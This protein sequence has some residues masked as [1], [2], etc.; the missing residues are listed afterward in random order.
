MAILDPEPDTRGKGSPISIK[1]GKQLK[2]RLQKRMADT[3]RTN[4]TKAIEESLQFVLDLED[5][6]KDFE[7]DL[8]VYAAQKG[9]TKACAFAK[10]VAKGLGIEEIEC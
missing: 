2:A 6:C 10:L 5:H 4:K 8:A 3:G 1:L 7:R 9:I